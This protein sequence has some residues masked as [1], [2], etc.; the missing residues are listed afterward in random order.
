[1]AVTII[2][3]LEEID[4]DHD[5]GEYG[6]VPQ[7]DSPLR[8]KRLIEMTPV[9]ESG[10]PIHGGEALQDGIAFLKLFIAFR[11]LLLQLLHFDIRL[12][13]LQ[14]QQIGL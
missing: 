5:N 14:L 11:Q 7:A 9:G 8:Q 2:V 6:L 1:V 12:V 3:F 10:Q 4:I 13:T